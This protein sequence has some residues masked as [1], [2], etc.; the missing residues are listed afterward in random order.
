MLLV[1][2]LATEPELTGQVPYARSSS[3]KIDGVTRI[4]FPLIFTKRHNVSN[5]AGHGN[6]KGEF[7]AGLQTCSNKVIRKRR[8]LNYHYTSK[9]TEYQSEGQGVKFHLHNTCKGNTKTST[10]LPIPHLL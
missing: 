7:G 6:F 2:A 3:I 9:F 8:S 10:F 4:Q 5:D 1:W